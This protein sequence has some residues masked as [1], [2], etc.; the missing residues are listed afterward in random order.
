MQTS[1][2]IKQSLLYY[3]RTNLA[4]VLGVAT[5]V[6][7]L[8][9]ALLVG[10]SVRGSLRELVVQRLGRTSFVISSS[11][12]LRE[13]LSDDI[14]AD[15]L[16]ASGGLSSACPLISLEGTVTHETS[17]RVAAKINVYGVDDRFW[18]FNQSTHIAP[19]GRNVF[20]SP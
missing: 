3:W 16:F 13:Q 17:K 18:K 11:G 6:S 5:A 14:Q 20:V 15:P 19:D 12:L 2:L 9:G 4:V 7:V 1:T 10:D 8:A